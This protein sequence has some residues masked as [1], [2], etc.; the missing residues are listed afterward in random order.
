VAETKRAPQFWRRVKPLEGGEAA[1]IFQKMR[2]LAERKEWRAPY[3]RELL[4]EAQRTHA[5]AGNNRGQRW[6]PW[7]G[8]CAAVREFVGEHPGCTARECMAAVKHHYRTEATARNSMVQWVAEGKVPGVEQRRD[9]R[10][11]RWWIKEE[12]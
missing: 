2:P 9:G 8:T 3:L 11:I 12:A 4:T 6:S 5:P 10:A 1:S 7:V